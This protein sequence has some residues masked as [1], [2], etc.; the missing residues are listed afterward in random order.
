MG[1]QINQSIVIDAKIK[2]TLE[3][4]N[5]VV[6]KLNKGLRE[7][8]TKIDLTKGVGN[9]IS[10]QIE[11]FKT[12]YSK[13]IQL[14]KDGK[15]EFG[16]TKDAIR[17]GEQMVKTFSELK[18]IVGNF[19]DMSLLDAKKMF[20][21]AFDSKIDLLSK[22]LNTLR[23]NIVS[24]D[25][26]KIELNDAQQ[27]LSD[28]TAKQQA[29]Q[30]E[31]S[32]QLEVKIDTETAEQNLEEAKKKI[33]ELRDELKKE[34]SGKLAGT[35]S[36][37]NSL[38]TRKAE[39]LG[40]RKARGVTSE[41][42]SGA[43]VKAAGGSKEQQAAASQAL[44]LYNSEKAELKD[45]EEALKKNTAAAK[46]YR[47]ALTSADSAK[48]TDL[49]DKA[50]SS[51]SKIN[52]ITDALKKQEQAQ[53]DLNET[54]ERREQQEAKTSS[55]KKNL[56]ETTR[57]LELQEQKVNKLQ[58]AYDQLVAK[59]K[60]EELTKAFKELGIDFTPEMVKNEQAVRQ[61][62]EQLNA[63][64]EQDYS[65]L[66]QS[67][68]KMGLSADSA[69]DYVKQ[70]K[71]QL[72]TIDD[73]AKDISRAAQEMENLKNQ[74]LQFFSITNTIQLFKRTVQS[75][76]ATVKEL[77]AVM[78]ETAVVTDFTIGDMWE[79]LPEYSAKATKLGA[80]IRD[81]Y[82]ATTLYYQ[83]G[84]Q[85]EEAMSVGIETMKMARIA[86]MEAADATQA[87]TAALRGF[88]MEVNETNAVRV[89]D[90]YSELAAITAADTEQI[91][92]AMSKTASIA[93]SANMEFETT[94][95]LLAQ[96]IE[97]TQ[98]APETAGTA[99]KT[100]IARFT[101]VKELFSEGMLTGEDSEGEEI[102]IN[103]IDAALKTV[104]I[105]LKDFLNGK[106]GIDDIFL[107]LASK[108]D[109]LDLATQRYIATMAAGSR[110]QSRF[111]AMMSN[112]DR[113]MELV[114][115]AN[116]SAGASQEQF[117]K[118]LESMEAKLQKLKNAWDEFTMGLA[119]NEILKFGVDL[120]TGFLETV[121][122]L[123]DALSGGNGLVKSVISLV[124]VIGALKGGNALLSGLFG[125][126]NEQGT[127]LFGKFFNKKKEGG[128]SKSSE[129]QNRKQGEKDGKAYMSGW[130]R[131][132][133]QGKEKGFKAGLKGFFTQE[134]S[135]KTE[136]IDW[137][138]L[139]DS[140]EKKFLETD[141]DSTLSD[142][143]ATLLQ[144]LEQGG[145]SAEEAGAKFKELGG[146]LQGTEP[147]IKSTS[148]DLQSVGQAT[149]AVG[150]AVGLLSVLFE[151]MGWEEGAEGASAVSAA[152]VTLGG[153]LSGLPSVISFV[154]SVAT[155]TGISVQA[156]WIWVVG[157]VAV[158]GLIV[159]AVVAMNNAA[160]EKSLENRM[161][162]AAEATKAAKETA[163]QTREAYDNLLNEKNKYTELQKTLS[164]LT[165][166][167]N[168]WKM[169]LIEANQQVLSLLSTYP[170]LAQYL[171]RGEDGQLIIQAGGWDAALEKQ[172]EAVQASQASVFAA[173][174]AE[175]QLQLE[176]AERNL[177]KQFKNRQTWETAQGDVGIVKF[178]R[179]AMAG[180]G[181]TDSFIY[182]KDT[183]DQML[184]ADFSTLF[185]R[186]ENGEFSTELQELAGGS[187][188]AAEELYNLK[189][190]LIEYKATVEATEAQ[191]QLYGESLV[192][193]ITS[194]QTKESEFYD[195][196][197]SYFGNE[198]QIENLSKEALS[199]AK[200]LTGP[201]GGGA[202]KDNALVEEI[203]THYKVS[204]QMTNDSLGNLRTIYAAAA[205][206]DR[207]EVNESL[208]EEQLAQEITTRYTNETKG[209]E[210]ARL[211]QAFDKITDETERK[212]AIAT[213]TNDFS[214][215]TQTEI[216]NYGGSA[217]SA[218]EYAEMMGLN[219]P[220]ELASLLGF[221]E[222]QSLLEYSS[223]LEGADQQNFL[224][225]AELENLLNGN[226]QFLAA[227]GG[228]NWNE[229]T[230]SEKQDFIVG[231][232]E[233]IQYITPSI[234]ALNKSIEDFS[235]AM[236]GKEKP[237]IADST[238]G[239][240]DNLGFQEKN[241]TI[242]AQGA[243]A[244]K[245]QTM[246][247]DQGSFDG[248][249]KMADKV[250]DVENPKLQQQL[251][252]VLN[253]MD[254]TSI[255]SIEQ[256]D[257]KLA[258]LGWTSEDLSKYGITELQKELEEFAKQ[259]KYFT[260]DE[261]KNQ[262]KSTEELIKDIEGREYTE[263]AF[264]KED[265]EKIINLK[266]EMKSQFVMTGIDEFT[267]IGD[268][269]QTLV[270]ALQDNTAAELQS[271]GEQI[272]E[273]GETSQKWLDYEKRG[274]WD[275]ANTEDVTESLTDIQLFEKIASKEI[276]A[277][278]FV[279][280]KGEG[281]NSLLEAMYIRNM[282]DMDY[283]KS[284]N[285]EELTTLITDQMALHYG[286]EGT[287]ARTNIAEASSWAENQA[288]VKNV[289][290]LESGQGLAIEASK[291]YDF[292]GIPQENQAF[293]EQKA[294]IDA[295]ALS[296]EGAMGQYAKWSSEMNNFGKLS[297]KEKL[298]LQQLAIFSTKY[299]NSVD[300]LAEALSDEIDVLKKG[301]KAGDKYYKALEKIGAEAQ[302]VFGPKA[303]AEFVAANK[304]L[305][306]QLAKGGDAGKEAFKQIANDSIAEYLKTFNKA[307]LS[308]KTLEA[309]GSEL[310]EADLDKY[311]QDFITTEELPLNVPIDVDSL[312]KEYGEA[313]VEFL[314]DPNV[315]ELLKYDGMVFSTGAD[316]KTFITKAENGST[317][318]KINNT[319]SGGSNSKWENPYDK[320]YN[321]LRE[322][323]EEL[324]V[325]EQ[326]ERRYQNLIKTRSSSANDLYEVSRKEIEQLE[327]E[328]ELQE[329]LK[330]G[331]QEQIDELVAKK[332]KKY[333]KY[334]QVSEGENGE[335]EIRIN[336]EEIDKIKG[337]KKGEALEEYISQLEEWE[338]SIEETNDTLDDI[339]DTIY[340]INERGKDE[341]IDVENRTKDALVS[342]YQKQ[343]DALSDINESINDTN[344]RLLGAMQESIEQQ[345][346]ARENEKTEEELSNKQRRLAYLR[347]DTSGANALEI[348]QLEK[349]LDEGMESYTDQLID[350]KISE[351]QKQNDEAAEQR[352]RQIELA[353]NQLDHYI[354][355]GAIWSEVESLMEL[356]MDKE[357]GP[358]GQLLELL[359][360]GE[361]FAGL[362]EL[363]KEE[364]MSDLGSTVAQAL[365]YVMGINQLENL[366]SM[367]GKTIEVKDKNG[368]SYTGTVDD[369]GNFTGQDANGNNVIFKDVYRD[370]NGN[371]I[372]TENAE[373][374]QENYIQ[375][376]EDE[377]WAKDPTYYYTTSKGKKIAVSEIS[378]ELKKG[379]TGNGVRALQWALKQLG[380]RDTGLFNNFGKDTEADL[381]AFQKAEGI[382]ETG[383]LDDKTRTKFRLKGYKTGGLADF[384]GP[385][386][387]DGTKANPEY[388]LNADQTKAFF[389]L[390]DV[391][392]GLKSGVT[393]SSQITGDSIYDVD[394][395]VESIGSDYD[396]EQLAQ[397]VKRMINDDA[398]YRNNNAIN[399]SR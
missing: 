114:T 256:L 286:D 70:L 138:K 220:E 335:R 288:Y 227:Y 281:Y 368:N 26:K 349:E 318:F 241:L 206:I 280:I 310:E 142:E 254:W 337:T 50:E 91:A 181:E 168:D 208:T 102:N 7:G 221:E 123:T 271:Y 309:V 31:L 126:E 106:K 40:A 147:V 229:L 18:R 92:T 302:K 209:A 62:Q 58:T 264:E 129:N 330:K 306:I 117:D 10:K 139:L 385:A 24:L 312:K 301:D 56:D 386:W 27:A 173:Q 277:Q 314:K 121:N 328:A 68:Q 397:T 332:E 255:T 248:A 78:T 74:V 251:T 77:D 214:G 260:L 324:R 359:K 3:G 21:D 342:V 300:D 285:G 14:T 243:F 317:G 33:T 143:L 63:L 159:G 61:L 382:D 137:E 355:T 200:S 244:E 228:R 55:I 149:M 44:K 292:R 268:S 367:A 387:L 90:V 177:Q 124:T 20:P 11:T 274:N 304:K 321:T 162:K 118:T 347:Q 361:E 236:T 246:Y 157:I 395:N 80:S 127:G 185:S 5:D 234:D 104:G 195:I 133:E 135:K 322:I 384:T 230:E 166:G 399:L 235:N 266:P 29:L 148:V 103:K 38:E 34:L 32:E 183:M 25:S 237:T 380:Y 23:E 81:L 224:N 269:M 163:T 273:R 284:L 188:I 180:A 265:Y 390:V 296:T 259:S 393:T 150:G 249:K 42:L 161:K 15:L 383:K 73:S 331:R 392:S 223:T 71:G 245:L 283:L 108:W 282:G 298:Q 35:E 362:S 199:M 375:I 192:D 189:D 193:S 171:G 85:T 297:E 151:N 340:E 119:N 66:I 13:F 155:A 371:Y 323:N 207:S 351:L 45:I 279:D 344:S 52:E 308:E 372:T 120:L 253:T 232:G 315:Q 374:G 294:A 97:T 65:K 49:A 179:D 343:I 79:K 267:Y 313:L 72:T 187:T 303:N 202:T 75:A 109:G 378:S 225:S 212:Y 136:G 394:I 125:K 369:K 39:I 182:E 99:M 354:E 176:N 84:L 93:K 377:A 348:M 4:M 37:K 391:L 158:I 350:Q 213:L 115:A 107:E 258:E 231:Y 41:P 346:Q 379:S 172:M 1:K 184:E 19:E 194:E 319:G 47:K 396:V 6:S 320:F 242:G 191:M 216:D 201:K 203:A 334:V 327:K 167:T 363:G 338:D 218:K 339:E 67:L 250:A 88:N 287:K 140:I 381:K 222:G 12:E 96:I 275:L 240:F 211:E 113:T 299:A 64:D 98:E 272:K 101:E 160:K 289:K 165:E 293:L 152:L 122:K 9:S 154:G 111:I 146:D 169:A 290:D 233:Y 186:G 357:N 164:G 263:R 53:I 226:E 376:T 153:V 17:S 116:N 270:E 190:A 60:P 366:D 57:S 210:I 388:I 83:Q 239:I 360:E 238:S 8:T 204:A 252:D 358:T 345:R 311:I 86:N 197:K 373:K 145:I 219:S 205:G 28:L 110:Q 112:Y 370:Y 132:V 356:Y 291:S 198:S 278:D 54:N 46:E 48:L 217:K 305:F 276:N 307:N 89:N 30:K 365:A 262:I 325:R 100:I 174:I 87:M 247:L 326:L 333:G 156:A 51:E 69:E 2:T 131:A 398:R 261:L 316:G 82:G 105:S 341:L 36:I 389:E 59:I 43:Q 76:L 95:A 175:S 141:I 353:Q 130:N 144:S 215:L 329:Y 336:W 134:I 22:K 178:G 128:S 257:E 170:V 16:D 196:I 352:E 94:A 295:V 364:W